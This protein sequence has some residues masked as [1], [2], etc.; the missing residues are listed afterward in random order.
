MLLTT[1]YAC[2]SIIPKM[3]GIIPQLTSTIVD[4]LKIGVPVLLIIFVPL[5]LFLNITYQI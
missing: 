5:Q 4:L 2:G 1:Y 3:A